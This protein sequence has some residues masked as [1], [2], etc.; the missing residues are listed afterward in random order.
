MKR[1]IY[2]ELFCSVCNDN[3]MYCPSHYLF[4]IGEFL[5]CVN[6]YSLSEEGSTVYNKVQ[7]IIE[8]AK[9]GTRQEGYK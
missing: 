1:N 7:K 2:G 4:S 6:C 9:S 3:L 5:V 8:L